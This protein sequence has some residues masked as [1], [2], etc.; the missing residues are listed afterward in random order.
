MDKLLKHQLAIHLAVYESVQTGNR[1]FHLFIKEQLKEIG[2][3]ILE[4]SSDGCFIRERVN[5]NP[6]VINKETLCDLCEKY[7]QESVR[8][9]LG[10]ETIKVPM[11]TE[12]TQPLEVP[13][14]EAQG[15]ESEKKS[16]AK[17][18]CLMCDAVFG[19]KTEEVLALLKSEIS[20]CENSF[21]PCTIG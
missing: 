13:R 8:D 6:I 10:E 19:G 12:M 16:D 21:L 17:T 2:F 5:L 11:E 14:M 3:L 20:S 7:I 18:E 4:E 1:R 15:T 9:S